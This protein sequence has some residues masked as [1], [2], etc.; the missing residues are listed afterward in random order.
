MRVQKI[1]VFI[2]HIF[3]EY[4]SGVCQGIIDKAGEY[5]FYVDIFCTT[6]G[7]N[8]GDYGQGEKSILR[9]PNLSEYAGIVFA[10]DTYPLE[11]L[12]EEIREALSTQCHCPVIEIARSS[13]LFPTI[14]LDNLSPVYELTEHLIKEHHYSRIAYL[15]NSRESQ[16]S[17]IRLNYYKKALEDHQIPFREEYYVCTNYEDASIATAL[18]QL[19]NLPQKPE[20]I[21]CYNDRMALIAMMLL[22]QAG[23][24]IP[25]DIALTG[26]DHLKMG[27]ENTPSLTSITFPTYELG[28]AAVQEMIAQMDVSDP[29]SHKTVR[30]ELF[31]GTSCGC[32]GAYVPHLQYEHHLDK[33][34]ERTEKALVVNINMSA[35]LQA[36]NEIDEATDLL[37]DY[38][39]AIPG[40]EEFYLCLY[41]DWNNISHQ[42]RKLTLAEDDTTDQDSILLKFAMRN[43]KRLP[44][45]T[46][47]KH[48]ALPEY[49]YKDSSHVLVYSPLYFGTKAFGYVA[50]GYK[51]NKIR[52]PF[53][54][55]PWL[56]NINTMLK[57]IT[58]KRNMGLLITRLEDIYTKD[59]LTGLY[60]RQGFKLISESFLSHAETGHHSL[61]AA[62]FDLDGLK[63][64]NDTYGHLEGNFAIQVLG[65]AL[66]SSVKETDICA[67]L[68]GD[69]F[70]ILGT[71]YT[72]ETAAALL[73]RIEKYLD[74][75]N[76]LHTKEYRISASGGYFITE[77]FVISDLQE[78]FDQADRKMYEVKKKKKQ[79]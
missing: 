65:H 55:F 36:V 30:A 64:I 29:S 27:Q 51:Y 16:Y 75:Y 57:D 45:C 68:G 31:L 44:E 42:I 11:D 62:V 1:G 70:Y 47:S 38:V 79:L 12:R 76:R 59:D 28:V 43:G 19:L 20:V 48:S 41:G 78:L 24:K 39:R 9:I 17:D 10:S 13:D 33:R 34:I 2:S 18:E 66:D 5:G 60:N 52:Y 58:D 74:N 22:Q 71:D 25:E 73:N 77:D 7:E 14:E 8:L 32:P 56:M 15:G 23:L 54:F 4:Q 49:I 67:R 53:T 46:F 69:E 63:S 37:E 3:G 72:E 6:D 40:C 61:F 21:V 26:C 35:R 50:M